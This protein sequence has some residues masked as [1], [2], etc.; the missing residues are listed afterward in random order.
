VE[1]AGQKTVGHVL[2]IDEEGHLVLEEISGGVHRI[3]SGSVT[4][5]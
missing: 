3:F 2:D 5:L 4:F 1:A